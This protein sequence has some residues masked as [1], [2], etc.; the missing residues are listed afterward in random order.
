MPAGSELFA[1]YSRPEQDCNAVHLAHYGFTMPGEGTCDCAVMQF[2]LGADPAL[3]PH[4]EHD[5]ALLHAA[6]MVDKAGRVTI[7]LRADV[8]FDDVAR[9]VLPAF[10]ATVVH[11][12]DQPMPQ[13]CVEPRQGGG[14]HQ[15]VY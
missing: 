4:R 8:K 14:V 3:W 13:E 12:A 7:Q 6:G 15:L 11:K 10:R 2:T 9:A 5:I 1:S